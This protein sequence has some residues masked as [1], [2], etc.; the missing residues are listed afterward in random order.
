MKNILTVGELI[1]QL[2]MLKS[3]L[4]VIVEG[5]DC[6]AGCGGVRLVQQTYGGADGK[7]VGDGRTDY[8]FSERVGEYFA[9]VGRE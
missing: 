6:F 7:H 5:C 8:G 1:G 2:K 4:P 3:D 9:L